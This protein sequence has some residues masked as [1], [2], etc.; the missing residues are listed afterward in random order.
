MDYCI[1]AP[2]IVR[3]FED[4][5]FNEDGTEKK[6]TYFESGT[7][8]A[9]PTVAGGMALIWNL[10]PDLT[11]LNIVQLTLDCAEPL[12]GGINELTG[13]GKFSLTCMTDPVSGDVKL[14]E[15]YAL[16]GAS[17][18]L[19]TVVRSY[20]AGFSSTSVADS[21]GRVFSFS[22]KEVRSDG[23]GTTF[24]RGLA[25]YL[26]GVTTDREL[27][28]KDDYRWGKYSLTGIGA[29]GIIAAPLRESTSPTSVS[30]LGDVELFSQVGYEK[31]M[32]LGINSHKSLSDSLSF[33]T[34]F[35]AEAG[36]DGS[37]DLYVEDKEWCV[38]PF[39]GT[40]VTR[41]MN[42]VVVSVA[43][44]TTHTLCDGLSATSLS[45]RGSIAT[46]VFT[47]GVVE[48]AIDHSLGTRGKVNVAGYDFNLVPLKR[49]EA[50]LMLRFSF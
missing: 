12:G 42:A 1:A 50:S 29:S 17:V 39:L 21:Y 4:G 24:A 6:H 34:V 49:T 14:P 38:A 33:S 30:W 23:S 16:N 19:N 3:L 40:A 46:E 22:L 36:K 37:L 27:S 35:G 43:G 13:R 11:S 45:L 20:G 5:F 7:S 32:L 2:F 8:I 48:F 28:Y 18:T 47:H 26:G 10:F 31:R 44:S 25:G 41:K 9:A 15:K